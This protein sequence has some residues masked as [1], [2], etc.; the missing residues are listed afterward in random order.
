M[1]RDTSFLFRYNLRLDPEHIYRGIIEF[2]LDSAGNFIPNPYEEIYGFE[3]VPD[4]I[5]REFKLN[6]SDAIE[7]AR[8]EGLVE[9]DSARAIAF[10]KWESLKKHEL[11][12]GQF[13][14]YVII[15]TDLIKNW[16]FASKKKLRKWHK[17]SKG[18]FQ[19]S[20]KFSIFKVTKQ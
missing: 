20:L 11:Y 18:N 14:F 17:K 1:W 6:F 16:S 19:I 2:E 7:K 10:L 15:K 9:S 5:P 12:N 13:R 4:N 3:K 8:K